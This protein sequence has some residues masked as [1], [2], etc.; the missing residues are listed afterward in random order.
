MASLSKIASEQASIMGIGSVPIQNESDGYASTDGENIYVNPSFL[1]NVEASAGEGGVRFVIAHELGHIA[2][3][4]GG[5]HQA[6]LDADQF[7]A[8]SVAAAGF[9]A[10]AISGVMSILPGEA[11]DSH[12]GAGTREGVALKAFENERTQIDLEDDS[13]RKKVK[14]DSQK[15]TTR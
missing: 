8:R 1:A 2:H 6:E 10:E 13:K 5:G 14:K 11:S 15:T 4:M 9:D 12:P 7:A 3:G